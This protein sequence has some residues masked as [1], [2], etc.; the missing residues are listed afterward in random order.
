MS[1]TSN[2]SEQD[3]RKHALY[4]QQN[5]WNRPTRTFATERNSCRKSKGMKGTKPSLTCPGA[6]PTTPTTATPP[7]H[8]HSHEALTGRRWPP[9]AVSQSQP[10][11]AAADSQSAPSAQ[12][13]PRRRRYR[14]RRGTGEIVVCN[15]T[16]GHTGANDIGNWGDIQD[17]VSPKCRT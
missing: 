2:N 12:G 15:K 10:P 6:S 14:R 16:A 5:T 7:P 13:H 4:R 1:K 3:P 9:S 8:Q 17:P 11:T